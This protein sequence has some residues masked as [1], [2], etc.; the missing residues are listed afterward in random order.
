[1]KGQSLIE[2]LIAIG[3]FVAMV[4]A[5]GFILIGSYI[6]NLQAREGVI[7]VS[8]AEEGLEAA[9]SIRNESWDDLTAGSHGLAVA[10]GQWTFSGVQEDIS[11]EL[12]KGVRKVIVEDPG[13]DRKIITSKITWELTEGRPQDISLATSLT[14][15]KGLAKWSDPS[16]E[17]SLNISG[18]QD[19]LKIQAQGNYA[20][21]VR[22]GGS[23]DFVIIDI[24]DIQNPF[25]AGSLSLSGNPRDI[26]ISGN[27]AYVASDSDSQELQIVNISNP[28]T[29]S[30]IGTY[31]APGSADANG[32]YFSGS[33]VYLVRSSSSQNEFLII[34]VSD[35]NLPTISGSI[36]LN[37]AAN[38]VVVLGN[39]AHIASSHDSQEL[40]IVNLTL[41]S[42]PSLI[43]SYNLSN[44]SNGLSITG[45]GNR[46]ILGRANG[47][48]YLF[49]VE[50]PASPSLSGSFDTRGSVNDMSLGNDNNYVFLAA[51]S[52]NAEFQIVDISAPALPGLIGSFDLSPNAGIYGV[53]YHQGKDRVF[54]ASQVN[55]REFIIFAP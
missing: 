11:S 40:Q 25:I 20:Y 37:A 16:E 42:S 35:P 23:P 34:N 41:P 30:V 21:L 17:G 32:I 10:G 2:L 5:V 3:I 52:G 39:Y 54:A 53:A 48:I 24:T 18:S 4:S 45:F 8:L 15:W 26:A 43:G 28:A 51:D 19:G 7:A 9:R 22:A 36:N 29:P 38:D 33:S 46:V 50:N 14:N 13:F 55:D 44:D 1:M 27:Y 49:N 6:S 47:S 31:N 12:E